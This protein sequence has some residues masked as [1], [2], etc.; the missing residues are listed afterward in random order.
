MIYRI[1]PH[2]RKRMK[3]RNISKTFLDEALLQPTKIMY[4]SGRNRILIKKLYFRGSKERLLLIACEKSDNVLG[5]ITV[6]DTSKVKK[7]L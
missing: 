7:Y 4:D 5:I 1:R 6:I 2:A 3:E